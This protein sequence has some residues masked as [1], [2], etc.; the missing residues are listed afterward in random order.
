[1]IEVSRSVRKAGATIE[2]V[3]VH[4]GG[5]IPMKDQTM[6][7]TKL[8][9]KLKDFNGGQVVPV[10]WIPKEKAQTLNRDG[11]EFIVDHAK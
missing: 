3:Y 10:I 5:S 2:V 7:R 4:G 1:M 6:L 9:D 8:E 11:L